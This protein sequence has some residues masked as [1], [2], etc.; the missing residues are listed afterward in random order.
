[1]VENLFPHL[2][3]EQ[4]FAATQET[5]YMTALSG[6]ATFVLGIVLGLALFLTARGGLFQN[7]TLYSV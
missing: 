6:I 1:M 3:W 2:K 7:R 5:L 4:L